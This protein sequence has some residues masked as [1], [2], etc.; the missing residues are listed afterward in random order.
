M[1]WLDGPTAAGMRAI[2]GRA[3]GEAGFDP[4]ELVYARGL[5]GRAYA[6]AMIRQVRLGRPP[7]GDHGSVLA[8][9]DWLWTEP[10]PQRGSPRDL[11][12]ADRV[13]RE[14]GG[15]PPR[16][17]RMVG[18]LS[19]LAAL[20]GKPTTP[21]VEEQAAAVEA[22]DSTFDGHSDSAPDS[23]PSGVVVPLRR[24]PHRGGGRRR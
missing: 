1:S 7:L 2:A 24:Q 22:L 12:F 8:L 18:L 15:H 13:I 14:T 20:I 9:E 21:P 5:S 23:D 4:G 10:N 17:D 6:L 16:P 11:E 19:D 3:A